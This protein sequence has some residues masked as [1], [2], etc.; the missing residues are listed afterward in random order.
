MTINRVRTTKIW[1][2]PPLTSLRIAYLKK[3]I[4]LYVIQ[5]CYQTFCFWQ[6]AW[7]PSNG[8]ILVQVLGGAG[9]PL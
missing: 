9:V 4:R 2:E 5:N 3:H 8:N 6:N 1:I 7:K